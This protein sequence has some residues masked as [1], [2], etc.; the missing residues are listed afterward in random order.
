MQLLAQHRRLGENRPFVDQPHTPP[1]PD[2]TPPPP[3]PADATAAAYPA[4]GP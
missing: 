4:Q 2:G 1:Q 3:P